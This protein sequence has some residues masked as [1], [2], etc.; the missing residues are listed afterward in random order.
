MPKTTVVAAKS[1]GGGMQKEEK[2]EEER[3]RQTW[4]GS[5]RAAKGCKKKGKRCKESTGLTLCYGWRGIQVGL[6]REGERGLGER[7][8]SRYF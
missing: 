6:G 5:K 1:K 3:C 7:R 4:M 8:R 2:E